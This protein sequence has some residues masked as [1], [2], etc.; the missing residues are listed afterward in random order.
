M[1]SHEQEFTHEVIPADK[2]KIAKIWKVAG[3]LALVTSIEY[4]FAFGLSAEWKYTKITIFI[5]LTIVKAFYIMA[6]FMHLNHEKKSLVYS[7]LIPLIFLAWLI[8]ALL[9]E[10]AAIESAIDSLW[11]NY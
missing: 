11:I 9:M 4:V 6:E 3:I 7:I 8:I 2:K 1:A 5:G 10:S